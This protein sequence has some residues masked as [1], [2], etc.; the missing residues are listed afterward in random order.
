[1]ARLKQVLVVK[2]WQAFPIG[3]GVA[4][5]V[6]AELVDASAASL[7]LGVGLTFTVAIAVRGS[8]FVVSDLTCGLNNVIIAL[9]TVDL[10]EEAD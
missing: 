8:F 5:D 10:S 7:E 6:V 1:L 2:V 3:E 4:S 9:R